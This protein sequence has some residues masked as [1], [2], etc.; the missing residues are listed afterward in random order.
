VNTSLIETLVDL[1]LAR[2]DL[3]GGETVL[4]GY[5]GVGFFTRFVAPAAGKVIGVESSPGAVADARRN[6]AQFGHVE[7]RE[8]SVESVLAALNAPVDAAIFDPPRAGCGPE[9]IRHIV[10]RKIERAVYVSCDPSTLARDA[11]Q[12]VD[13][14]YRLMDV[15]PLDM[16]PHTFHLETVSTWVYSG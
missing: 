12:L 15:Q 13:G 6:L 4:D 9:V 16:F 14:G 10:A 8:G 3:Q 7:L 5:C 11:R 2:L 1:V